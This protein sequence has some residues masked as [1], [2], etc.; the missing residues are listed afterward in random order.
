[1]LVLEENEIKL[2]TALA[3]SKQ[4]VTCLKSELEKEK[5]SKKEKAFWGKE[6][7]PRENKRGSSLQWRSV[8]KDASIK[9]LA[10]GTEVTSICKVLGNVAHGLGVPPQDVPCPSTLRV[11]RRDDMAVLN[12][13]QR[14]DFL[15]KATRLT[16]CLDDAAYQDHK[17]SSYSV[18]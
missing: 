16:L 13:A 11:W 4:H 9:C 5:E 6:K 12:K 10:T 14:A 2:K 3:E 17:V 1:M 18:P 8:M 15:S 7:V